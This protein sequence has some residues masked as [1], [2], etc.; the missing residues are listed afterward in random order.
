VII[1]LD[2]FKNQKKIKFF[3]NYIIWGTKIMFKLKTTLFMMMLATLACSSEPKVVELK[4][5]ADPQVEIDRV[6]GNI[7]EAQSRQVD[8]LSPKN[9]EAAKKSLKKA[10]EARAANKD[11]EKVLHQIAISQAYLDKANSVTDVSNQILKGP[12]D[13]R[14]DALLAKAEQHYPKEMTAADRNFKKLT[15]QIEDNDTSRAES[16]RGD[17]ETK[18]REI[19]LSSIKKEK[20]DSAQGNIQEAIKEGAKK[21][22]PE[23]LA[24]AQ[25]RIA[26]DQ[27]I[28]EKDRHT[29]LIK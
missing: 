4:S 25:S 5:T 29:I 13:A 10:E 16:K 8:V 27:A 12:I 21:L 20:L 11:Q 6:N 24:W 18:Y 19:E 23:T 7:N 17:I 1:L 2:I 3:F 28:I 9:Y 22:T 14:K 15:E 26:E